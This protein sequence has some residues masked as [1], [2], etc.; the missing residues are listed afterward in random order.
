M[1]LT[2]GVFLYEK[3]KDPYDKSGDSLCAVVTG[4]EQERRFL[5]V[6]ETLG[7][8]PVRKI[9]PHALS[10]KKSLRVVS[11]PGSLR[12]VGAFALHKCLQL[13]EISLHDGILDF[14]NGVVRQDSRL[15]RIRL[16]VHDHNYTVM[17]DILSDTDARLRFCLQLPDGE[18][19]LLFPGYDYS[20]NENTMA[21]TIQFSILGSGMFYRECVRRKGIGW[22]EYDRLFPRVIPDD[23]H[24]AAEIAAD[25]LL[26]PYDLSPVHAAAYED[27]LRTHA[28]EVL[29]QFT[30]DIAADHTAGGE[31]DAYRRLR[32]MADR[33]LIREETA[34]PALRAAAALH[35][36]EVCSIIM[37]GREATFRDICS[38]QKDDRLMLEEEDV[39]SWNTD[40]KTSD[41]E[42]TSG[43]ITDRES[44]D[45]EM[46]SGGITDRESIDRERI[47]RE[48]IDGESSR[49]GSL[50]KS[51]DSD[52]IDKN[53][54]IV[55]NNKKID[56]NDKTDISDKTD[57]SDK[58]DQSVRSS[59]LSLDDW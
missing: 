6:P 19:R 23:A 34:D 11:F 17:R 18:A 32:L 40:R 28:R 58:T 26:Y 41:G 39:F 4:I 2:E 25:R 9:A 20:F 12:S 59:A 7:G 35:M 55:K 8:L 21:R 30:E 24:A 16:T 53:N 3:E 14:H 57:K 51:Y 45:G 38:V 46:T 36:T 15:H 47:Y 56:K 49:R 1:P 31:Q 52:K 13:Q 22:R 42:M 5:E 27:Y 10:D 48:R 29:L 33:G 43:E 54:T 37:A 50:F 44:I